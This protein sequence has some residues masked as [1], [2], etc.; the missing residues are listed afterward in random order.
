M[1]RKFA[2]TFD[3]DWANDRVIKSLLEILNERKLNATFFCT[4]KTSVL[5]NLPQN[6]ER[7]IHPNFRNT[8]NYREKIDELL[9]I[10]PEAKGIR[11]HGLLSSTNILLEAKEAGLKYESNTFL[12]GYNGLYITEKFRDFSMVPYNFSDSHSLINGTNK[13]FEESQ[14]ER[15]GL[16]V[17][18]FHPIHIY[19]NTKDEEHYNSIKPVYQ[20]PVELNKFENKS[21][22]IKTRFLRLLEYI[23]KNS[24]KT[25]TCSQL[26]EN[27]D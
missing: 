1:S 2:L 17:F 21:E 6:I 9:E 14:L 20:N 11:S 10:I 7:G 15:D 3:I 19:I 16:K 22:G 27:Q 24:I 18:T 26:L 25:Y 23:D 12:P 13:V 5:E 4:H 8:F